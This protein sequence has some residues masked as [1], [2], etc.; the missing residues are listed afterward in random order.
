MILGTLTLHQK[1]GVFYKEIHIA[2]ADQFS[3]IEN[4]ELNGDVALS[5]QKAHESFRVNPVDESGNTDYITATFEDDGKA[6]Y[7]YE[8]TVWVLIE[9]QSSP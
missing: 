6:N 7:P 8:I 1:R 9:S 3:N 2:C 4:N 5:D